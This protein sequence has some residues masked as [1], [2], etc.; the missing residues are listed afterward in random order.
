MKFESPLYTCVVLD[1]VTR[2]LRTVCDACNRISMDVSGFSTVKA[3]H[4]SACWVVADYG[5]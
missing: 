4:V 1:D 3:A 2:L 5:C